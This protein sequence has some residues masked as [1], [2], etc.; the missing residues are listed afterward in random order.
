MWPDCNVPCLKISS[1]VASQGWH[2]YR[3]NIITRRSWAFTAP[4][5]VVIGIQPESYTVS[6]STRDLGLQPCHQLQQTH[7]HPGLECDLLNCAPRA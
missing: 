6:R 3:Q 5:N 1:C 7:T 4:I 2:F